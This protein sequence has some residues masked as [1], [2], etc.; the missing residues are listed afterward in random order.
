MMHLEGKS[1]SMFDNVARWVDIE[2][3]PEIMPGGRLL[4]VQNGGDFSVLKPRKITV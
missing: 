1:L 3:G 4:H 2:I